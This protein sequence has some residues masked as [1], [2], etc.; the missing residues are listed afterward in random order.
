MTTKTRNT[1]TEQEDFTARTT[2]RVSQNYEVNPSE[3]TGGEVEDAIQHGETH[4]AASNEVAEENFQ[5]IYEDAK[6][7]AEK[8]TL[9]TG[10][11][12]ALIGVELQDSPLVT[13][14]D[15]FKPA[16]DT[17]FSPHQGEVASAVVT[18]PGDLVFGID[19]PRRIRDR[20]LPEGYR[21][22][23]YAMKGEMIFP[24]VEGPHNRQDFV[25][26]NP[27][28]GEEH[29]R[30]K[31][32]YLG[33]VENDGQVFHAMGAPTA[34]QMNSGT[35]VGEGKSAD[36]FFF[37]FFNGGRKASVPELSPA[38]STLF[39]ADPV[40][41]KN[42]E[43]EYE[44]AVESGRD[45]VY[46]LF[47]SQSDAVS[48]NEAE[49]RW[50]GV[51]DSALPTNENYG[52]ISDF[53]ELESVEDFVEIVKSR[54]AKLAPA[55]DPEQIKL[56]EDFEEKSLAHYQEENSLEK[57]ES[58]ALFDQGRQ[59][60]DLDTLEDE[61][62]YEGKILLDGELVDVT[63]DHTDIPDEKFMEL[64]DEYF[65]I[66]NTM[67]RPDVAPKTNG[68]VE[69]RDFSHSDRTYHA[70]LA[71]KAMMNQYEEV[72]KKFFEAG[73]N[74]ETAADFREETVYQG[75]NTEMPEYSTP[76]DSPGTE[77]GTLREFYRFELLPV[78]EEGVRESFS[79]ETPYVV[80][81]LAENEEYEDFED[82]VLSQFN[83]MGEFLEYQDLAPEVE[84]NPDSNYSQESEAFADWFT[85]TAYRQE[86]EHWLDPE[87]ETVNEE[88]M[89]EANRNSPKSAVN[90]K[91]RST[92]NNYEA[93]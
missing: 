58:W 25:E 32:R 57:E 41:E 63:V 50:G 67:V 4:E 90:M 23:E 36:Q 48:R 33:F 12:E 71:Q 46:D 78:L 17:D 10:D 19:R 70:L 65:K 45:M 11:R 73:V 1:E 6:V 75:L 9:D 51:L 24:D 31:P 52:R 28:A 68:V 42:S 82:D 27:E 37:E 59:E 49:E 22:F 7:E 16:I 62:K 91:K 92:Q 69:F 79:E 2:A 40:M 85:E 86:M 53:T 35:P 44:I 64:M 66:Q 29:R 8:N 77:N 72:Q 55:V 80:Q 56:G 39:D 26:G 14:E 61:R 76:F 3:N 18:N 93:A 43:G 20:N 60:M 21:S 88:L 30:P 83:S 81:K 84:Y 87:V 54:P 15:D 13:G 34:I 89:N 74:S 47:V 5:N 38:V